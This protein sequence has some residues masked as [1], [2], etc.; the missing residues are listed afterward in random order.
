MVEMLADAL[1]GMGTFSTEL[2]FSSW[3][4]PIAAKHIT[5]AKRNVFL[6]M[7]FVVRVDKCLYLI[8]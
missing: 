6:I 2:T 4:L 5:I 1:S 3:A 7:V 8:K